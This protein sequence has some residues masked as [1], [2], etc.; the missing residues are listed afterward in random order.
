MFYYVVLSWA[1]IEHRIQFDSLSIFLRIKLWIC[2]GI[3]TKIKKAALLI[4]ALSIT[5]SQREFLFELG[6][7]ENILLNDILKEIIIFYSSETEPKFVSH[8]T[9]WSSTR[10]QSDDSIDSFL[11]LNNLSIN[12][13]FYTI[14]YRIIGW[15]QRKTKYLLI[16]WV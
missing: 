15:H 16:D 13:T 12:I 4:G 3:S 10:L 5:D 14:R 1:Q 2:T 8:F 7:C 11:R 9:L 6:F